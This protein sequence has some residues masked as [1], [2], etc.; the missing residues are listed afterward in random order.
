M[1]SATVL[2]KAWSTARLPVGRSYLHLRD[3]RHTGLMLAAATGATTAELMHRAGPDSADAALRYQH[4][5][6]DQVLAD[7]LEALKPSPEST[8]LELRD[9][10]G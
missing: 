10:R 7:G 5:T 6:R 3:L 1:P 8:T 2:Q 4:A 9:T